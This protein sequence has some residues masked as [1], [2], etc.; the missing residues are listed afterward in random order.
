MLYSEFSHGLNVQVIW[1]PL[2]PIP[3]ASSSDISVCFLGFTYT[4]LRQVVPICN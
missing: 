3:C 4:L 1:I 2:R